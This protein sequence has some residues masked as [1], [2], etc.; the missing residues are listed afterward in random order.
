[1][2]YVNILN[3]CNIVHIIC[4]LTALKHDHFIKP[5]KQTN[6]NHNFVI[7]FNF[8]ICPPDVVMHWSRGESDEDVFLLSV[9]G[10]FYF[11]FSIES[12]MLHRHISTV[13]QSVQ[14]KCWHQ[15]HQPHSWPK[16]VHIVML[17]KEISFRCVRNSGTLKVI[18][19][20][21]WVPR[22]GLRLLTQRK[23]I[24]FLHTEKVTDVIYNKQHDPS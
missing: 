4:C 20:Q 19:A 16:V 5:K 8:L 24:I 15:Q 23:Y 18:P 22:Y 9:F 21:T 7:N 10:C 17:V 11:C 3:I 1:M 6:S 12:A 13:A 14:I 2:L